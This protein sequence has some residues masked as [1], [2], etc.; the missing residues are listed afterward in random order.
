M[1]M[2]CPAPAKL[3]G[4]REWAW[5]PSKTGH[6]GRDLSPDQVVDWV[7]KFVKSY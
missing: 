4:A 5:A 1:L 7:E 2:A 3:D 6:L